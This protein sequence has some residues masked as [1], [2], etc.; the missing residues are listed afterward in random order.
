MSPEAFDGADARTTR[1]PENSVSPTTAT[2]QRE[3]E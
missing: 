2:Q 1:T 3:E